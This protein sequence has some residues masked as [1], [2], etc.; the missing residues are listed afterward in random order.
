MLEKAKIANSACLL[1]IEKGEN[2]KG[3]EGFD[4]GVAYLFF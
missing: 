1:Q 4:S 3:R 2:V